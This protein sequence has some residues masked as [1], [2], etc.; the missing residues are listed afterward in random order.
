MK[1]L[2]VISIILLFATSTFTQTNWFKGIF[3][4]A[5]VTAEK[6]G[7]LILLNLTSGSF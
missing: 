6:E 3:D 1:K 2:F 5:K 7:K 4:E